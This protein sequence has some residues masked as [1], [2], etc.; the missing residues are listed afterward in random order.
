MRICRNCKYYLP[1]HPTLDRVRNVCS[2]ANDIDV[3]TGEVKKL[4]SYCRDLRSEN[5]ICGPF[6]ILFEEKTDGYH[7]T[8]Q[9]DIRKVGEDREDEH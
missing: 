4:Y 8:S 7:S 5:G 2:I 1:V 9:P 3:V 6:G